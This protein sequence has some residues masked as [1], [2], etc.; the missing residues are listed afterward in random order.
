MIVTIEGCFKY[1]SK[2]YGV[3]Y[4][5]LRKSILE[6]KDTDP[7]QTLGRKAPTNQSTGPLCRIRSVDESY[8]NCIHKKDTNI[9]LCKNLH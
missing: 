8:E 1:F 7:N 4:I 6:E 2:A 5:Y 3:P 9:D